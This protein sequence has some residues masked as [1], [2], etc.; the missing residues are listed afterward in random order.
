MLRLSLCLL[1]YSFS[2]SGH[3][4]A[5]HS[6][7]H[8]FAPAP[9]QYTSTA[10]KIAVFMPPYKPDT[11]HIYE[12]SEVSRLIYRCPLKR[13]KE[14][15]PEVP[16]GQEG[17]TG[18][19]APPPKKE[20]NK[21]QNRKDGKSREGHQQQPGA[22]NQAASGAEAVVT[23]V[24][25]TFIGQFDAGKS[26]LANCMLNYN[27]FPIQSTQTRYR[28]T[29]ALLM[30]DEATREPQIRVR[31]MPGYGSAGARTYN[32]LQANPVHLSEVVVFV[33]RNSINELDIRL[34][35]GLIARGIS[36]SHILFVRNKFDEVLEQRLRELHLEPDS[37]A[38]A[39][40]VNKVK[41]DYQHELSDELNN[42]L[43]VQLTNPDGT[44][45][46]EKPMLFTSSKDI[47]S[48]KGIPELLAAIK[49]SMRQTGHTTA[50]E[51]WDEFCERRLRNSSK[52][53]NEWIQSFITVVHSDSGAVFYDLLTVLNTKHQLSLPDAESTARYL[54]EFK[55]T[56]NI[57]LEAQVDSL[58]E[59]LARTPV[60]PDATTQQSNTQFQADNLD[61]FV[62]RMAGELSKRGY[63]K[64]RIFV[65]EKAR[66][67]KQFEKLLGDDA[68]AMS[69]LRAETTLAKEVSQNYLKQHYDETLKTTR[70]NDWLDWLTLS[71]TSVIERFAERLEELLLA[72]AIK[73]CLVS[74]SKRSSD[75][76]DTPSQHAYSSSIQQQLEEA[77]AT[78]ARQFAVFYLSHIYGPTIYGPTIYGP[79]IYEKPYKKAE[80]SPED[81]F[82]P[83]PQTRQSEQP[84][85]KASSPAQPPTVPEGLIR[86]T[87]PAGFQKEYVIKPPS[88]LPQGATA[89]ALSAF[90]SALSQQE[91]KLEK[92][93]QGTLHVLTGS[94][95]PEEHTYHVRLHKLLNGGRTGTAVVVISNTDDISA[96]TFRTENG[97]SCRIDYQT[98]IG[99]GVMIGIM[100]NGI[101]DFSGH[102]FSP[103]SFVY[104]GGHQSGASK[105]IIT[106]LPKA[107]LNQLPVLQTCTK[108]VAGQVLGT[109]H[110]F[111][112]PEKQPLTEAETVDLT[113]RLAEGFKAIA[114]HGLRL[115]PLKVE[116][117]ALNPDTMQPFLADPNVLE[118]IA[119]D[120]LSDV[121]KEGFLFLKQQDANTPSATSASNEPHPTPVVKWLGKLFT[122]LSCKVS[123]YQ[124]DDPEDSPVSDKERVKNALKQEGVNIP[125]KSLVVGR[126]SQSNLPNF[127]NRNTPLQNMLLLVTHMLRENP[128]K[129]PSLDLVLTGLQKIKQIHK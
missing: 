6:P 93:Q 64:K 57:E 122:L 61:G 45:Y 125:A 78:L 108:D 49:Q 54:R 5:R 127:S 17:A 113:I 19:N 84:V 43:R 12:S 9:A 35:Q 74:G 7:C 99:G 86:I 85:S 96:K 34:V 91:G 115:S 92:A 10:T 82:E 77:L 101:R 119:L 1:L 124:P 102:P 107:L 40:K 38:D 30:P 23:P 8:D 52:L 37:E 67:V 88:F 18:N 94:G 16:S 32:W 50:C 62:S 66:I 81:I 98:E 75:R 116:S 100:E 33:L 20:G 53:L 104:E 44:P 79:T 72:D 11:G 59:R 69:I 121:D 36:P 103:P 120:N 118:P 63:F 41:L 14:Q 55:K 56:F 111:A 2:I 21:K 110:P 80:Q 105:L 128:D 112:Q 70:Q 22:A 71:G 87:L 25:I 13:K 76:A 117:L 90:E 15:K 83:R 106:R 68:E 58:R 73:T 97:L 31:S 26:S 89:A 51:L 47:C 48:G 24:T 60:N 126:Y 3:A 42:S 129:C 123:D 65:R 29:D 95:T 28:E 4:E 46:R 27:H 114:G 39:E 109:D